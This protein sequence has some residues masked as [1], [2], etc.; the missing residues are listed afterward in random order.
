L[1]KWKEGFFPKGKAGRKEKSRI[2][3]KYW[4]PDLTLGREGSKR[5]ILK[6]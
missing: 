3:I 5:N 4:G 2:S 6:K 1:K